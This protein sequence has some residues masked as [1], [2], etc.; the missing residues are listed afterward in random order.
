[1]LSEL[2]IP[3]LIAD[4]AKQPEKTKKSKKAGYW[5]IRKDVLYR[6]SSQDMSQAG[7]DK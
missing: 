5:S 1:M 4:A 7:Y 2:P 6:N 3:I